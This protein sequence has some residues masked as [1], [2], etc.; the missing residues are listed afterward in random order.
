MKQVIIGGYNGPLSATAT[1]YNSL[2]CGWDWTA[3]VLEI[4]Q[5][6]STPGTLSNLLIELSAAPGVGASYTITLMKNDI[7][8]GL[9][10]TISGTD[11][12][13]LDTDSVAVVAGDIIYLRSTYSGAPATP[14]ARWSV[15]FEGTNTKESLILG[16]NYASSFGT[17]YAPIMHGFDQCSASEDDVYQIIPT[18]GKIK[19][20]YVALAYDPGTAPDAYR[21]TLRKNGGSTALTVTI[22]ADDTTGNNTVDEIVVAA[23]DYVDLMIERLNTPSAMGPAWV[24]FTFVADTDGESLLLGQSNDYPATDASEYNHLISTRW[25][26]DWGATEANFYQGGQPMTLKKLYVMLSGSPGAGRSYLIGARVNGTTRIAVT[27]ADAATT[28]N[29]VADTWDVA[30]FDDLNM[31]SIPSEPPEPPALRKVFWGLV[32]YIAPAAPPVEGTAA[33]S[34]VGLASSSAKL[35]VFALALGNGI[36]LSL[37]S[38]YLIIPATASGQ[39]IGLAQAVGCLVWVGTASG[40]GIGTAEG[41]PSVIVIAN[42]LGSGIGLG[43]AIGEVIVII[44]YGTG[45]GSGIGTATAQGILDVL[46]SA[47]GSGIGEA[48]AQAILNILAEAD[49]SGVGLGSTEALVRVLAA[50]AASGEGL[51]EAEALLEVIAEA[52][53]GGIGEGLAE[54]ILTILAQAQASGIGIGTASGQVV[55]VVIVIEGVGAGSGVGIASV[56]ALL[57]VL[58]EA[59]GHGIGDGATPRAVRIIPRIRGRKPP[60]TLG[61]VKPIPHNLGEGLE[62]YTLGGR[63]K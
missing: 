56:E 41:T 17:R 51:G 43:S 3:N 30:N 21:F 57:N 28:G 37:A 15:L 33:G 63:V 14:T 38:P 46:A 5:V 8:T 20:L 50:A 23:G 55:G 60:Y 27:I 45:S 49:G 40:S 44:V 29:N 9:A 1:E 34:G 52:A 48:T 54:A 42:A 53:G 39:G 13:G 59:L 2:T 32:G 18:P 26:V 10:V 19:N 25:D 22:T 6:V 16:T 7:A 31:I 4:K 62:E 61:R 36:G 35:D 47:S 58:A 12:T 11:T 24:G